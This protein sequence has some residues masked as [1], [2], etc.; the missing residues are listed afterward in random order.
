LAEYALSHVKLRE[1]KDELGKIARGESGTV[2]N[3]IEDG[4]EL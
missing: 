2:S 4:S 3:A 1:K